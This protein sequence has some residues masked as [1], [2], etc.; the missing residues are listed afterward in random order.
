MNSMTKIAST[1]LL[2]LPIAAWAQQAPP[3]DAQASTNASAEAAVADGSA[4]VTES[5]QVGA[6]NADANAQVGQDAAVA[7]QAKPAEEPVATGKE[8]TK[9]KRVKKA[10]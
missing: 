10:G 6:E 3:A 5:A 2:C 9:G 7:A 4:A 1:L 8:K